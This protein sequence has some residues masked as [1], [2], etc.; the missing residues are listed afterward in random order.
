[1]RDIKT[2]QAADR[3]TVPDAE[4]ALAAAS[5]GLLGLLRELE[6][7]RCDWRLVAMGKSLRTEQENRR[8]AA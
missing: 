4:A 8:R 7:G 3:F 5:G 1:V 6:R 2:G